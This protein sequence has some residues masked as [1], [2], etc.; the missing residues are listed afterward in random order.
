M[1]HRPVTIQRHIQMHPAGSVLICTGNTKVLCAVSVQP[2]VPGFVNE[3]AEG[4]LTAE[5]SMLPGSSYP[6]AK[7]EVNAGHVGGRTAEIQRI[8]GRALRAVVN[9]AAFPG[10]TVTVDCD[11][12]QADGGTRTASITGAC[13]ALAD[14]FGVMRERGQLT[15]EPL[16]EMVAAVSVGLVD[17]E[18]KVDLCYEEDSRA[19]VDMN[20]V[21][22]ESGGLVEVQGTAE[23]APFSRADL[24]RMMNAAAESLRSLFAAQRAALTG[25]RTT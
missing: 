2:G 1:Q 17:G 3:S 5:Y 25:K 19:D 20:V 10:Y 18:L 8:I 16:K 6:R 4:W 21:M 9:R 24:D 23:G 13:V 14:A 7:R 15:G 11:V 22:T 12:L